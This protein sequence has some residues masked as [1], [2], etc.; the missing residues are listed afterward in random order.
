MPASSLETDLL[1]SAKHTRCKLT[2][3]LS[4][5]SLSKFLK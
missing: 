4:D 5:R 1:D 3:T 2:L